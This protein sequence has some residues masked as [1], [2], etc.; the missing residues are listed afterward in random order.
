MTDEVNHPKPITDLSP[1]AVSLGRIVDRLPADTVHMISVYKVDGV[2]KV[3]IYR[4]NWQLTARHDGT[5]EIICKT[6]E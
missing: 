2:W 4:E 5:G 6:L 3:D 1:R